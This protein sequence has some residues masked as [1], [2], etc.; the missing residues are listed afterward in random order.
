MTNALTI[1]SQIRDAGGTPY[2]V[3]GYVRD[4]IMGKCPKDTDIVVVGFSFPQ[5]TNLFETSKIIGKDFPVIQVDGIEIALARKERKIDPGHTGFICDTLGVSLEEDLFRRDLTINAMAM[6]PFTEQI[7]DPFG[8][9]ADINNKMIRPVSIHFKEDPLRVLR[10]ARFAAQFDMDLCLQVSIMAQEMMAELTTLTPERVWGE[11]LKAL[12]TDN[13]QRFFEALNEM[14]VLEIVFPEIAALKGRIQPEKYH[15]EGDAFV[16]TMLAIK[17]AR[18]LNADDVTMFATLVHDLGKAV[19]P[20]EELPHHY[21]HEALGVPIVESMCERLR[22]PNDFKHIACV[23]AREHLN[24]HKFFD[25]KTVT[26]V[27]LLERLGA[28]HGN[29]KIEQVTLA[30]QCD[31]QGRGRLFHDK[32]YPQ[33]QAIIDAA[34]VFRTVRGDQFAHLSGDSIAAKMEQVRAKAL[35]NAGF[36]K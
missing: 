23:T 2:I 15:P 12:K 13:P 28:T 4:M 26:R 7:T 22:I 8:G 19:T 27:R 25:L 14:E 1:C 11:T 20:D 30:A 32:E 36:G 3:G 21:N 10:A 5:L 24:I 35:Q 18:E 33:R 34:D 29:K 9:R 17:R 6:D 31:A 16:H